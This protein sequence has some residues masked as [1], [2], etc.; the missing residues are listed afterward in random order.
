MV[1]LGSKDL[2]MRLGAVGILYPAF[3]GTCIFPFTRHLC[4]AAELLAAVDRE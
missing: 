1:A 3:D 4:H 2:P